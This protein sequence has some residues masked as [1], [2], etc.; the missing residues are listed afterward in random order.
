MRNFL[1]NITYYFQKIYNLFISIFID[2][3]YK[4]A[5]NPS[6]SKETLEAYNLSRTKGPKRIICYAPF[7]HVYFGT[8]G[9]ARACCINK[10]DTYGAIA[11]NKLSDLWK[12]DKVVVL[13]E[14]I[15]N[16]DLS[17]GCNYCNQQLESNNFKAFEGRLFD[18]I[19][20]EKPAAYPTEMTFE[21]STTCNLECIMCNGNFSSSIRKNREKL[22]PL[23]E[24]YGNDFLDSIKDSIPFLKKASFIGGEP[25]LIPQYFDII[26][27]I[28][29]HNSNCKI[30]IQTN[31]TILNNRVK[32]IIEH[33]NVHL[34]IS[35]D[36]LNKLKYESIRKNASFE[37]LMENMEFF[38]LRAQ[39]HNQSVNINFCVM[40]NN[41]EEVPD[42]LSYCNKHHFSVTF[43]PVESPKSLSISQTNKKTLKGIADFYEKNKYNHLLKENML[44]IQKYN[45]L[46]NYVNHCLKRAELFQ[47]KVRIQSQE[48]TD[49][50]TILLKYYLQF[51]LLFNSND[52]SHI[53]TLLERYKIGLEEKDIRHF[54]S[55]ILI[56]LKDNKQN[57]ISDY[58]NGGNWFERF[59]DSLNSSISNK[60]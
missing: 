33:K 31:G 18:T 48:H 17:G 49:D 37:R 26:E 42:M 38:K 24:M 13:R 2:Y 30:F 45:D 51:E 4:E 1:T 11:N 6:I 56:D 40:T 53:M 39:K 43:I 60:F 41:W 28:L 8:N 14:K 29:E 52:I 34:S 19:L 50:L 23:Q 59:E 46:T 7:K 27:Y 58:V 57:V 35:I 55:C 12:N 21:I 20:P 9:I 54:I 32:N 15:L 16:Y 5:K 10:T 44:N 25:F 36:S 3:K 22:P 47:E